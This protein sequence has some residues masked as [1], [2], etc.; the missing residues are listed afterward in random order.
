MAK[1]QPLPQDG[2]TGGRAG[3]SDQI[4]KA[5]NLDRRRRGFPDYLG[6]SMV[7]NINSED[8]LR[9]GL[10]GATFSHPVLCLETLARFETVKKKSVLPSSSGLLLNSTCQSSE[11]SLVDL[12][13]SG[14]IISDGH[15]STTTLRPTTA[16]AWRRQRMCSE[17]RS[18]TTADDMR[19]G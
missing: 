19:R 14:V 11:K 1:W 18:T 2:A 16:R 12:P 9:S 7:K 5:G 10:E 6:G 3:R 15:S 8:E 13:Q 17:R 4:D